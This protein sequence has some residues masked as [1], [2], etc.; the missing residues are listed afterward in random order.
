L[1]RCLEHWFGRKAPS[2]SEEK[3]H[4][5]RLFIVAAHRR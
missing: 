3:G 4:P 5:Q 2:R 1:R